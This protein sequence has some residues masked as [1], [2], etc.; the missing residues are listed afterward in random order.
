M[1]VDAVIREWLCW[2]FDV[3]AA[4]SGL[5][6]EQTAIHM[7]SFYVDYGVSSARDPMWLQSACN[8][9]IDLF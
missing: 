6:I 7:A 9:L 2:M 8:I 4:R 3:E 5:T 1:V